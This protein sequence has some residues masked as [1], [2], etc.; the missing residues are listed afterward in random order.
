MTAMKKNKLD[1]FPLCFRDLPKMRETWPG[2]RM[3]N[4]VVLWK[5]ESPVYNYIL[6]AGQKIGAF[7]L[8]TW[9]MSEIYEMTRRREKSTTSFFGS[10]IHIDNQFSEWFDNLISNNFWEYSITKMI[11]AS[12]NLSRNLNLG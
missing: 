2:L 7:L 3:R 5:K 10:V 8:R 4:K 12:F 1:S 9:S 11:L 6:F